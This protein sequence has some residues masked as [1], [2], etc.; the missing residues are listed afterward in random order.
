MDSSAVIGRVGGLAVMLGIGLVG[1][2]VGAAEASPSDQSDSSADTNHDAVEVGSYVK[3]SKVLSGRAGKLR[4]ANDARARTN[5][6]RSIGKSAEGARAGDAVDLANDSELEPPAPTAS[7]LKVPPVALPESMARIRMPILAT[8]SKVAADLL[9]T[10]VGETLSSAPTA[11]KAELTAPHP[12]SIRAVEGSVPHLNPGTDPAVPIS[13]LLAWT[14]VAAARREIESTGAVTAVNRTVGSGQTA[15]LAAAQ[16]ANQ[17]PVISKI[18]LGPPDANSGAVTGTVVAADPNGDRLF[19]AVTTSSRGAVT[20][21]KAGVFTYIPTASALHAAARIGAPASL[22]SAIVNVTV[23]DATGAAATQVVT[24]MISPRNNAPTGAKATVTAPNSSNGVVTG[25]VTATDPDK[26]RLSFSVPSLTSRGAVTINAAS[27]AFTYTPTN[28]ARANAA[29][30]GATAAD[31]SDSFTVTITDSHGGIAAVVVAV[32]VAPKPNTP[33]RAGTPTLNGNAVTG[34]VTGAVNAV[35]PD[36]DVLT[37]TGP[38][39]TSKGRVSVTTG[40]V[41]TYIPSATARHD[42]AA[43]NAWPSTKTDTFTVVASDGFGGTV[44]IPIKVDIVPQN[45]APVAGT[46]LVP[47][48][49]ASTGAVIG[50]VVARDSDGDSLSYSGSTSTPS[51]KVTV[52]SNGSFTYTPTVT[53]RGQATATT[54]DSFT[55]TASDGYGGVVSLPVTVRILP[56]PTVAVGIPNL[57]T[58]VVSGTVT[59]PKSD[60]G[61]FTFSAPAITAKG[62]LT[63]NSGTGAFVYTPSAIARHRASADNAPS[64]DKADTFTVALTDAQGILT[65]VTSVTVPIRASQNNSP[66]ASVTVGGLDPTTGTITGAII[67]SDLEGD[68]LIYS[69][70]RP[71]AEGKVTVDSATGAFTYTPVS[72]VDTATGVIGGFTSPEEVVFGPDGSRAYISDSARNSVSVIDTA[73]QAIVA[74]IGGLSTP[75]SLAITPDGR[76]IYVAE[77]ASVSILDTSTNAVIGSVAD[78]YAPAGSRPSPS[79]IAVSPDGSLVYVVNSTY[80]LS[81]V[82]T[83]T[84]KV[85]ATISLSTSESSR[86]GTVFFSPDARRAYVVSRGWI[87]TASNQFLSNTNG[88]G[89]SVVFNP[90]GTRWYAA[91]SKTITSYSVSSA[92][93]GFATSGKSLSASTEVGLYGLAITPAGDLIYGLGQG[94]QVALVDAATMTPLG[95]AKYKCES[96]GATGTS[97]KAPRPKG[98]AVSPDGSLVYAVNPAKGNVTVLTKWIGPTTDTFAVTIKDGHGGTSTVPVT[99]SFVG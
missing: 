98:I 95:N 72:R 4:P 44:D 41:F 36:G 9:L 62:S 23:A 94:G 1:G 26:D 87:D 93:Y 85:V 51:G 74:V 53:A 79:S 97:T 24:V 33:P 27:G 42:A 13:S 47:R 21:T 40:G 7:L 5:S 66:T 17:P 2:G 57:T 34:V 14:F 84:N 10:A 54:T 67:A 8:K 18:S 55:I 91:G 52:A 45:S 80:A 22:T 68:T 29:R 32:E 96:C 77:S 46:Q 43:N 3:N 25:T 89:S 88:G 49:D 6:V 90:D 16:V 50:A 28:T 39:A 38:T 37:Y 11:V 60:T 71:L 12:A 76:R 73:T 82:D 35:D 19:Y 31:K 75:R 58:G 15:I 20:I 56:V 92:G 83:G 69:G 63:I 64:A 65:Y 99:V 70:S 61:P 30:L 78:L 86:F 81:I 48:P 59:A